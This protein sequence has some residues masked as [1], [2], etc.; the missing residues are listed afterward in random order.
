MLFSLLHPNFSWERF[1]FHKIFVELPMENKGKSINNYLFNRKLTVSKTGLKMLCHV[2][3]ICTLYCITDMT[4][5]VACQEIKV[6]R[7]LGSFHLCLVLSY[8][9]QTTKAIY[10]KIIIRLGV[11]KKTHG[12]KR[13]K[14]K[15]SR[16]G[17][18]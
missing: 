4:C 7:F 5:T 9:N 10:Q 12:S 18:L 13:S 15:S 11:N 2:E 8:A 3:L 17:V 1:V 6:M 16:Q 14:A